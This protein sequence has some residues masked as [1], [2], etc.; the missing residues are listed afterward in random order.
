MQLSRFLGAAW[1]PLEC[2]SI[3]LVSPELSSLPLNQVL[4]VVVSGVKRRIPGVLLWP[5]AS[6]ALHCGVWMSRL[7][8]PRAQ[9]HEPVLDANHRRDI[10][11]SVGPQPHQPR[12]LLRGKALTPDTI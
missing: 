4:P 10:H 5:L 11:G 9:V 6:D 2:A 7:V 3:Q 12:V 1:V 8:A